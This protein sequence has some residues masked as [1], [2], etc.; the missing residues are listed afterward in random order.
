MKS[1]KLIVIAAIVC[2]LV[3]ASGAAMAKGP[4]PP[5]PDEICASGVITREVVEGNLAIAGGCIIV[6]TVITGNVKVTN[7]ESNFVMRDVVVQGKVKITGG[8]VVVQRTAIVGGHG[9]QGLV[10]EDAVEAVVDNTLVE[11]ASMKFNN[12]IQVLILNNIVS[13][14]NIKCGPGDYG[15]G[16]N[17]QEYAQRNIVPNGTITCYGQ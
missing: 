14:G 17:N 4:K 11:D 3:G 7:Y 15:E 2:L 13:N 9:G 16:G 6:D 12:N 8:K 1:Q 5:P 10:I